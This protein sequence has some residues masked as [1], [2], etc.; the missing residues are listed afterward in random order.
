MRGLHDLRG[1]D[2]LQ[3]P[4]LLRQLLLSLVLHL[5]KMTEH[6]HHDQ[7]DY[8]AGAGLV[9]VEQSGEGSEG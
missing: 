4:G 2:L 6:V 7:A 3:E 1:G 8:L 9:I 5:D